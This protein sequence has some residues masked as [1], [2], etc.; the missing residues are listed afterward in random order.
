[1]GVAS[2]RAVSIPQITYDHIDD[3]EEKKDVAFFQDEQRGS[4]EGNIPGMIAVLWSE[5]ADIMTPVLSAP[6]STGVPQTSPHACV[7]KTQSTCQYNARKGSTLF[8]VWFSWPH[9]TPLINRDFIVN[10]TPPNAMF[11]EE[12][13]FY[14]LRGHLAAELVSRRGHS[15]LCDGANDDC[16]ETSVRLSPMLRFYLMTW[17]ILNIVK[18]C[19]GKALEFPLFQ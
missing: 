10:L 2:E 4:V 14:T 9:F 11:F 17:C 15:V 1:M 13:A 16:W 6:Y 7:L 5:H 12:R 3:S 18:S 19:L 8:P